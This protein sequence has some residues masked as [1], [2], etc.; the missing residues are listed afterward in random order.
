MSPDVSK[1][2]TAAALAAAASANSA[3]RSAL[4]AMSPGAHCAPAPQLAT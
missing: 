4:E 2:I 3:V 1:K